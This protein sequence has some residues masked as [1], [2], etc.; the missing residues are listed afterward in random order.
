MEDMARYDSPKWRQRKRRRKIIILTVF[1]K[2]WKWKRPRATESKSFR[3]RGRE[4]T[5]AARKRASADAS[6]EPKSQEKQKSHQ[7]K[8]KSQDPTP[9]EPPTAPLKVKSGFI[10]KLSLLL[11][12]PYLYLIFHHYKID[13][14]LK[15][16]ILINAGLSIAGFFVTLKLIPVASRYV[17]RRNLFGYDINKKGTPGGTLRV[18]VYLFLL[19]FLLFACGFWLNLIWVCVRFWF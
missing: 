17:I 5:M 1:K 3:E 13:Q 2:F 6:T 18:W 10:V 7:E 9:A 11:L 15:R 14:D 19:S 16:S 8:Q 12:G 4:S